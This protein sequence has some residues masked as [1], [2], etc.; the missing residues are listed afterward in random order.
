MT[1]TVT[2][3][4]ARNNVRILGRADGPVLLFAHGFGT[5]QDT[6]ERILPRFIADYRVVLLDHVG[7]GGSDM[8]AYD[9]VKY[10]AL[11]GYV[12]DLLDICEELDLHEVTVIGHS[13]GAMM[14]IA[15]A[16]QAPARLVRLILMAASPSYRDHPGDNYLG[17]FSRQDLDDL[18][19]SLDSNYLVWADS[20]APVF[21]NAPASPELG[22]ELRGSFGRINPRIARDFARVAFLSDVRH[23]LEQVA[24]PAL[25]L[26]STDDV[27]TPEHVGTYLRDH[28]RRGTLVRLKATGHFPHLSAPDETAQAIL[29]FLGTHS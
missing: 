6:W 1:T 23:L 7:S 14:A 5:D 24:L 15:L 26:Q 28:L 2:T 25:I 9:S 10:G 3:A 13:I 16:S 27:V 21:M 17:G 20:M 11:E 22:T 4:R 8:A 19:V 12:Q 29:D 18:F